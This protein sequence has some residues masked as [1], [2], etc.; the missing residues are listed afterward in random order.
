MVNARHS[1]TAAAWRSELAATLAL[2]GPLVLAN[3]LQMA[4]YATDVIFVARLGQEALA[5]SSLSVTL[6]GLFNW[7]FSGL[8]GAVAP[9]IAAELGGR[10]HAVRQI[11][12]S[13]RM[14]LWLAVLSGAVGMAICF[15][16]QPIMRLTGQNTTIAA[17]AGSFLDVLAWGM[18]PMIAA[19]V[20]RNF[21]ATLGRPAFAT[22][23]TAVAIGVNALGNYTLIYGHFGAPALGL[24]GSA[25]ASVITSLATLAAYVAA[26]AADRRLRRY[27]VFGSWWRPDWSRF[28]ALLRI[29]VPI[30]FTILAEAGLFSGAA[31]LMG[32]IGAAELAAHTLALQVAA[33]AFQ[34]PMGVS[35]AATIRVGYHFGSAN[36]PAIARAGSAALAVAVAFSLFAVS[37]MLLAPRAIL[38]IYLDE[39]AP[40]AQPVMHLAIGYLAIAAAFQLFDGLQAVLA[41]C[42]R[43]LQDTRAPMAIAL[44]GYWVPGYGTAIYLGFF[45]PWRGSGVWIGLAVGLVVVAALLGWRWAWRG[46]LGL[47]PCAMNGLQ[48]NLAP[49]A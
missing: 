46:R 49:T 7:S 9:L 44:F 27:Y 11:R 47:L 5:A 25:L 24:E 16:G 13:T 26:I 33:F 29:G 42:L 4:V 41:G 18:V 8:T 34:V 32:R 23:I 21:V 40:A 43:G 37:A 17:L 45:T 31:F 39:S 2:A 1:S 3:L 22:V 6:F 14:A 36:R 48:E 19:S 28:A 35:Q 20:L 15:A 30:A 10:R 12:R 38:S